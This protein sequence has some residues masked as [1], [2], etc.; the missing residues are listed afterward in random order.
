MTPLMANVLGQCNQEVVQLLVS[1]G[2]SVTL[3]THKGETLQD[4][5]NRAGALRSGGV[6]SYAVHN[7]ITS[8]LANPL[9]ALLLKKE[10]EKRHLSAALTSHRRHIQTLEAEA[11]AAA[12]QREALVAQIKAKEERAR[13]ESTQLGQL[14]H[15]LRQLQRQQETVKV[16]EVLAAL[17][18][19]VASRE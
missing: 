16:A 9:R 1:A 8:A 17:Q 19:C 10:G 3:T 4:I 2:A 18:E 7:W 6:D 14:G 12:R 15:A 13:K 5:I 11:A